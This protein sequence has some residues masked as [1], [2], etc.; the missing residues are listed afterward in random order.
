MVL[1]KCKTKNNI[2]ASTTKNSKYVKRVQLCITSE[3]TE[4][5][6]DTFNTLAK[7]KLKDPVY[8]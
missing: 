7:S 2:K 6:M 3:S 1:Y 4:L 8:N 5:K